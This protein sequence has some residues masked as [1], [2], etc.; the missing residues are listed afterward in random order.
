MKRSNI[1]VMI[2]MMGLVRPLAGVMVLASGCGVVGFCCANFLP[3]VAVYGAL[4]ATSA[5]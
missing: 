3:V 1:A 5:P 4:V 2:R